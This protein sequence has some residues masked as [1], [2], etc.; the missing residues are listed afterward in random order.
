MISVA[1]AEERILT[2]LKPMPLEQV[3]ITDSFGRVVGED[4]KSRRTQPPMAVSAMDGYAV[5]A[6]EVQNVPTDLKV[7]AGHHVGNDRE[8]ANITRSMLPFEGRRFIM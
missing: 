1:E 7:H 2:A 3:V 4:V 8:I 6:V 5:R